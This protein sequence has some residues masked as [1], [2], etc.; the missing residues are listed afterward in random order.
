MPVPSP[1]TPPIV[2]TLAAADPTGGGGL[3]GDV[4]TLASMGCHPLSVVTALCLRDTEGLAEVVSLDADLLVDQ[5][6]LLLEDITVRAFK[7]G[8]LGSVENIAA[9]AEILSD[10]PHIPLVL[11]SDLARQG[12][13]GAGLDELLAA[14]CE[15]LLPLVAVLVLGRHEALRLAMTLDGGD[16]EP[17]LTA[18]MARL[19]AAGPR[20]VLLTGSGEP[21][22]QV[23]N[24]LYGPDGVVRTDAW[25]RLPDRYLG[26]GNTLSAAL[27]GALAHGMD[28]PEAVRE[29]QE[30]TWQSLAAAFRP[31]MGQALPDRFF[32]LRAGDRNDVA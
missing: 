29:A 10:Y 18:A 6:R 31:G 24:V 2:M 8:L 22:P 19:I 27:V 15:M 30:F 7:V 25:E 5:A 20:Y 23:V 26:A 21:G 14:H 4:L 16:D 1:A 13:G 32:W 3:Q 9:V 12:R 17:E 28:V 11:E